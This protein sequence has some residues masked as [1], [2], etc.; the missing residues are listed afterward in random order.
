MS[1]VKPSK[2]SE[3]RE[4]REGRQN[5]EIEIASVAISEFKAFGLPACCLWPVR[6]LTMTTLKIRWAQVADTYVDI[7]R[8]T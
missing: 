6:T 7:G 8:C 5:T 1:N 2:I 4:E 3:E